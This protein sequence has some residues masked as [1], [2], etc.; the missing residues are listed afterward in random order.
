MMNQ[1][2]TMKSQSRVDGSSTYTTGWA[3]K[4]DANQR[5]ASRIHRQPKIGFREPF[6]NL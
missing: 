4:M 3:L 1:V 5:A 6:K 2:Y